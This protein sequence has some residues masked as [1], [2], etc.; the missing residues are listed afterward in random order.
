MQL[1]VFKVDGMAGEGVCVCVRMRMCVCLC[2]YVCMRVSLF[3]WSG[4]PL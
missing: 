3:R 1:G 2:V 4:L